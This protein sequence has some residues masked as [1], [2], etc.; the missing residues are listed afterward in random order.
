MTGVSPACR[1]SVLSA[2]LAGNR[3]RG[4]FWEGG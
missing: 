2:A 4:S 3:V 1:F